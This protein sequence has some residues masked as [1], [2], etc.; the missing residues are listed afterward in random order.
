MRNNYTETNLNSSS[1]NNELDENINRNYFYKQNLVREL[2]SRSVD[3]K[4][5]SEIYKKLLQ[6]LIVK[7]S[8]FIC[9]D[10]Q[11]NIIKIPCWH[12]SAERVIAKLKQESNITLPVISV[13][14]DMDKTDD[15]RRRIDS[16]VI[17]ETYFDRVKNRAVRV[18]SL[19]T[20]PTS[21]TY[22]VN[23]W[24]K[25]H[26]DMD[27][28]SEQFR[29]LF[30][31]HLLVETIYSDQTIGFLVEESS[32]TDLTIADGQDRV[33][34]RSFIVSVESYIPNP[35]FVVTSTGKIEE[36]NSETCYPL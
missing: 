20:V 36:F 6:T 35:K 4:V 29:R 2:K 22:R 9:I 32:N 12:G 34:R 16:T 8:N 21:I 33:V 17:F 31:P 26:E 14:R 24:T 23:V 30:N 13:A 5:V 10:D 1:F 7:F 15:N 28:I 18:A 3:S 11:D 19:A 25:Y 27:Q